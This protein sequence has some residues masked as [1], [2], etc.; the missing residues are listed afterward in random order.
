MS[1]YT[2]VSSVK[3]PEYRNAGRPNKYPFKEMEKGQSFVVSLKEYFSA[4]S[5][6]YTFGFRHRKKFSARKIGDHARIWRTA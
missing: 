3:M 4:R 1:N 5:A 2:V 6:A